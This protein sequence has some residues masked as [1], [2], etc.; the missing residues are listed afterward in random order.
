MKL[1]AI[2]LAGGTVALLWVGCAPR[3]STPTAGGSLPTQTLLDSAVNATVRQDWMAAVPALEQLN[4][5]YPGNATLICDLGLALHN[6]AT[7][8]Q[9]RAGLPHPAMRNSLVRLETE[10][11]VLA[12]LDSAAAVATTAEQWTEARERYAE[13]FEN[14]GL[15]FDAMVQYS[16]ILRRFPTDRKSGGRIGWV[17]MRLHDPLVRDSLIKR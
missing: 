14:M 10:Q 8:Q 12:L 5:R 9:I 1:R 6:S 16:K 15:P 4:H 11:R 7:V 2:V 3:H 13:T 17:R